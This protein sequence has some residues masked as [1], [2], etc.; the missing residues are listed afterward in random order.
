MRY[1]YPD[2]VEELSALWHK[3]YVYHS[4]WSKPI[5]TEDCQKHSR[6]TN[7]LTKNAARVSRAFDRTQDYNLMD[8]DTAQFWIDFYNNKLSWEPI[9]LQYEERQKYKEEQRK[10]LRKELWEVAKK[11]NIIS[12]STRPNCPVCKQPT[13]TGELVKNNYDGYITQCENPECAVKVYLDKAYSIMSAKRTY[14]ADGTIVGV[15]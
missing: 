1:I 11:D 5:N 3:I 9:V 14:Y 7:E 4:D 13:L 12:L 2:K 8:N 6:M 10:L 15:R